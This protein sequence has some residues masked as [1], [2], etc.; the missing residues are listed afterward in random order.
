MPTYSAAMSGDS[1]YTLYLDVSESG[2]NVTNN[3]SVVNYTLRLGFVGT[4]GAWSLDSSTKFSLS[5]NGVAIASNVAYNYDFRDLHAQDILK[6]GSLTVTHNADG[7][8][9][10]ACS[11]S[12]TMADGKGAAYP[13]GT[14]V[15]ATIPRA[16]QPSLNVSTAALGGEII[17]TTN[18]ASE[19]FV[20][21]LTYTFGNQSGQIGTIQGVG[22][23]IT[24]ILPETLA[25]AITTATS[26]TGTIYCTTYS[27]GVNIGQKSVSFTATVPNNSTYQPSIASV[28]KTGNSLLNG[29]YVKT[30]STVTIATSASGKY[31]ATISQITVSVNGQTLYGSSVTSAA[32]N[33]AGTNNIYVTVKDSR[34][35]T[36]STSTSI[37]VA[38]YF[39]P[40]LNT[41]LASRYPESSTTLRVTVQY[42]VADVVGSRT[43]RGEV[44]YRQT[45]SVTWTALASYNGGSLP[46]TTSD[47]SAK[48]DT[49]KSYE[50]MLIVYDDYNTSGISRVVTVGTAFSLIN[51]NESGRAIAFGKVSEVTE[52]IEFGIPVHGVQKGIIGNVATYENWGSWYGNSQTNTGAIVIS[53]GTSNIMLNARITVWSYYH[54]LEIYVGGYTYVSTANWHAPAAMGQ[55]RNGTINVR[56]VASGAN[57]YIVIGETNTAWSGH[58]HVTIDKLSA[59]YR[60]G[61][62]QPFQI[63]L[64]T[65][66]SGTVNAVYAISDY[67]S[68]AATLNGKSSAEAATASTI[69]SRNA[70]GHLFATHFNQSSGQENYAASSYFYEYNSDGYL[71]KKPL[72]NVRSE[73]V[74]KAAVEAALTGAIT[75]HNHAIMAPSVSI[76]NVHAYRETGYYYG[77]NITNAPRASTYYT[78]HHI[79]YDGTNCVVVAYPQV[80]STGAGDGFIYWKMCKAGAW[81]AWFRINL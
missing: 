55:S 33:T 47:Y 19:S 6:T 25:K 46:S 31:D 22:A 37:T 43:P 15:L 41:L 40:A 59:G 70:S 57:R 18:R 75:S 69:A 24:W 52:G 76:A 49:D 60:D 28:T 30:K 81:G 39:A 17:I 64:A 54:L 61:A 23:N 9:S 35:Y 68:D 48:V 12:A 7:S 51:F 4:V 13:S 42:S 29:Q 53:L 78:Y 72:A 74:T 27:G 36:S 5:I 32:L 65:T 20:H 8:K 1:R 21:T 50:V 58:L 63:S 16:S 77:Y 67:S 44:K 62:L 2:T 71:R 56:F 66:Y 10:V 26:G 73:I 38:D 79:K 11:A 34:G 80:L 3:T 45:G 14:F